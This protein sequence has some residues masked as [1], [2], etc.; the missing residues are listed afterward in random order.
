M[1]ATQP[2]KCAL[3]VSACCALSSGDRW[4][5]LFCFQ[6]IFERN[7]YLVPKAAVASPPRIASFARPNALFEESVLH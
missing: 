3:V 4:Q 5:V 1:F 7:E 2:T 6:M